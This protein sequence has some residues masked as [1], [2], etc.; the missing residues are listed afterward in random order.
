MP[1]LRVS[2]F[3][4]RANGSRVVAVEGD[5]SVVVVVVVVPPDV[6]RIIFLLGRITAPPVA[7]VGFC[8]GWNEA[9]GIIGFRGGC[10]GTVETF[11]IVAAAVVVGRSV[12]TGVTVG[13]VVEVGI[14]GGPPR[15]I[16]MLP[17][18]VEEV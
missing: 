15:Q 6:V 1:L 7:V 18:A 4:C 12:T 9:T 17:P 13:V 14:G 10:C 5:A 11:R 3:G 16:W 2:T 8:A